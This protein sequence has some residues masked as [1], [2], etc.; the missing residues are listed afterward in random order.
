MR[1]PLYFAVE[2]DHLDCVSELLTLGAVESL[3]LASSFRTQTPMHIAVTNKR[4][5]IAQLLFQAEKRKNDKNPSSVVKHRAIYLRDSIGNIAFGYA[6][7]EHAYE[8]KTISGHE[9][10]VILF[11]SDGYEL[12]ENLSTFFRENYVRI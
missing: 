1:S 12:A 5:Q 10:M 3:A 4:W 7:P 8:L 6:D 11:S 2:S 9:D